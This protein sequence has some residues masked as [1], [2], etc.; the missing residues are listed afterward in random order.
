[1]NMLLV[2]HECVGVVVYQAVESST[3]LVASGDSRSIRL[4]EENT[5]DSSWVQQL[6]RNR[7]WWQDQVEKTVSSSS[8]PSIKLS[9]YQ[10]IAPV[11]NSLDHPSP[12]YKRPGS[13]SQPNSKLN[14]SRQSL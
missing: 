7:L 10:A 2:A 11:S 12:K 3:G 5:A 4:V 13:G 1:M 8:H 6:E 9:L 14:I